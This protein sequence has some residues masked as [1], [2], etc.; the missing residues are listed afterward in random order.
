MPL[1]ERIYPTPYV[2]YSKLLEGGYII[3]DNIGEYY[4]GY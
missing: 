2:L 1:R 3:G 4:E